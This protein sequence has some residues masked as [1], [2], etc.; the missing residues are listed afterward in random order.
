MYQL[1]KHPRIDFELEIAVLA[2]ER[3]FSACTVQIGG[4]GLSFRSTEKLSTAEPLQLEFVL[5]DGRFVVIPAVVWWIREGQVGV[6]FDP[7]S[8]DRV[9]VE[10][11]V[12]HQRE[13]ARLYPK[14]I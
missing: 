9:L 6:R 10:Q 2:G 1:R 7:A 12:E 14:P 5:P 8:P 3:D 11:W 13:K 4:G